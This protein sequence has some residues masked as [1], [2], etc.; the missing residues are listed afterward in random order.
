MSIGRFY[1]G[2]AALLWYPPDHAYLLLK[3]ARDKDFASGIWECVTGRVNQGE[4]FE[5]ALRREV[6]EEIGIDIQ[7]E[8][9]IGTTHFYR[10]DATP[11]NEL[12]GVTYCCSTKT[13]AAIRISAEHSEYRWVTASEAYRLLSAS[14]PGTQWSKRVIERAEALQTLIPATLRAF[15]TNHGFELE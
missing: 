14:D 4:G 2:V 8:F 3:R 13:P 11:D 7:I 5:D 12:I 15:H 9:F 10:G 1:G 6:H